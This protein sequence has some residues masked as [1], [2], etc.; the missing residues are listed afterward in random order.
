MPWQTDNGELDN[1]RNVSSIA[2]YDAFASKHR[3]R[4]DVSSLG[5]FPP[6][7][8]GLY[9]MIDHGREWVSDWYATE[10]DVKQI[11]NPT[12]PASGTERVQ[13]SSTDRDADQL[14]VT[15]MTFTRSHQVPEPGPVTFADG[16]VVEE[17]PNPNLG[18]GF[19]CVAKAR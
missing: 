15:S 16:E 5:A 13:R 2:Q 4:T 9:D 10:Y 1:G 3:Q 8:L 12:G 14:S 18:N 6:N 17:N 19:R 11:R 7:A